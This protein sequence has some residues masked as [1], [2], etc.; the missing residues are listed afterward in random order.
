MNRL[1]RLAAILVSASGLIF[2]QTWIPLNNGLP[3]DDFGISLVAAGADSSTVNALTGSGALIR[4]T[5]QGKKWR[6]LNG[7]LSVNSLAVAP[8]DSSILY[9]ATSHGLLRSS[10]GGESW[11]HA[12][13]GIDQ[14]NTYVGMVVIDPTDASTVYGLT[15]PQILKSTDAG[16]SWTTLQ[17]F[18]NNTWPGSLAIDPITPSILYVSTLQGAILKSL[19][20]GES[21]NQIKSGL[22][23]TIF[24]ASAV[25]LTIDRQNP[26][27]IYAGSFAAFTDP[28]GPD[29]PG[30]GTISKSTDGGQT[31]RA[32]RTGI[33]EG[34]YVHSPII[35]PV[36][37]LNVYA[38]FASTGGAGVLRST[39][40]GE[41][42]SQVY[43]VA[44]P[45]LDSL[46]LT[47]AVAPGIV[48][49]SYLVVGADR[50]G[51]VTSTDGGL[52]WNPA[53]RGL[54]YF[55]LVTLA[56][57]P[58]HPGTLYAGGDQGLFKKEMG[59]DFAR[60]NVPQIASDGQ[61]GNPPVD[62]L[63]QSLVIDPTNPQVLYANTSSPSY[64][65][66]NDKVFFKSTDGGVSWDSSVSPLDSGCILGDSPIVLDPNDSQTLY[67]AENDY[68]D[69]GYTLLKS[70]DGGA[71]WKTIWDSYQ[72]V[73]NVLA[74]DPGNSANL[75]A[76]LGNDSA[77][78]P[79]GVF[80]SIDGGTTW[81]STGFPNT[82][83]TALAVDPSDANTLYAA[84]SPTY[85]PTG[86]QAVLKSTDGGATWSAV[87]HGLGR[88]VRLGAAITALAIDPTQRGTVY[89][90][91]AG[92]GVY[93]TLD[94]GANWAK[95]NRGLT[96]LDV[97][98][99]AIS[100]FDRRNVY[101]L[102]TGGIFK[103]VEP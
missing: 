36:N 77:G 14:S 31:W 62:A 35:D 78:D 90:A 69:D 12:N 75:Y 91:T 86:V 6:A 59:S 95:F 93:R 19:D 27:N 72:S 102:T 11:S 51:M 97:R 81:S 73:L 100:T 47:V 26:S 99:I 9:A 60:L 15:G 71:N 16:G 32:I 22:I 44:G 3:S 25:T 54:T 20:G 70:T 65:R 88:P 21:W 101:A 34:V 55:N 17:D 28:G 61:A 4:S 33:P 48:Y 98:G 8:T 2:G 76:G 43:S 58:L 66:Y 49:A 30:S 92:A 45:S 85:G 103:L 57:D 52:T 80:K 37:P 29:Q 18:G 64:C 53:N 7:V 1:L 40:G 79:A 5:D 84:V 96:R 38:G 67:L 41:S 39:D 74:I 94:G 24:G 46:N 42:W 68:V 23:D 89:A 83:I 13:D 56:L 82:P 50:G 10:D 63:I 87:N